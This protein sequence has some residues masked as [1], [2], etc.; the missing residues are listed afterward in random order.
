MTKA[1]MQNCFKKLESQ[2]LL[3]I[4][5][6][7]QTLKEDMK[8]SLQEVKIDIAKLEERTDTLEK[9]VQQIEDTQKSDEMF[10]QLARISNNLELQCEDLENRLRRSNIRIKNLPESIKDK[11]LQ[12]TVTQLFAEIL[13]EDPELSEH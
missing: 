8:Q 3:S 1:D 12:G 11:N 7:F 5:E 10:E 6:Q 2:F 4:H 9:V 13:A